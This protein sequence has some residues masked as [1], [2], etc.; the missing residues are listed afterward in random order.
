VLLLATVLG[1]TISFAHHYLDGVL[2]EQVWLLI[3]MALPTTVFFGSAI[4]SASRSLDRKLLVQGILTV[5]LVTGL[6]TL[7]NQW[8]P[9]PQ[10]LRWLFNCL[11][12]AMVSS[13]GAA[14]GLAPQSRASDN[15]V[16]H[17]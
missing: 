14:S 17:R 10:P 7:I 16:P 4:V 2:S 11:T 6:F 12:P 5:A 13:L 8:L 15:D 9:L 3:H 1:L